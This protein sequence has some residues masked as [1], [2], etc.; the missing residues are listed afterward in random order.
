VDDYGSG[1]PVVVL[2]GLGSFG[3]ET[4]APLAALARDMRIV[5][6]DRP[7]YGSSDFA[8]GQDR[9]W[10]GRMLRSRHIRRP[11][12]VA[13]SIGA[14]T[15][16]RY[17]VRHPADV[18]GL[19]L[20]A[21]FCK[22]T[23][24]AFFPLLRLAVAPLIGGLVRRQ[25]LPRLLRR[26]A[27]SHLDAVFAPAPVPASFGGLP[28]EKAAQPDVPLAMARDLRRFNRDV[29]S[30]AALAGRARLP[31]VILAG[32][33]DRVIDSRAHAGWLARRA[34]MATLRV[35]P[36]AGHMLHHTH[37]D[38]VLAAVRDMLGQ[39]GEPGA[40]PIRPP[41]LRPGR[42]PWPWR[43]PRAAPAAPPASA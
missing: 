27:P 6:P 41:A 14:I 4:A 20:V 26:L 9:T 24:P 43:R 16:L 8:T 38:I 10:F 39:R 40:P 22:P 28:L 15:A 30:I 25:V 29:T 11:V 13:H 12:I 36:G 19:V 31:I 18:A 32:T 7:G 5:V 2:H 37:P 35:V 21:P 33:A 23:P 17:A 3:A 1:P 34:P 42:L